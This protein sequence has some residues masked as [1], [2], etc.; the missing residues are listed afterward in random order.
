MHAWNAAEGGI[1]NL[2]ADTHLSE[3]TREGYSFVGWGAD[4]D[5]ETAQYS[6]LT[7]VPAGTKVYAVWAETLPEEPQEDPEIMEG[8]AQ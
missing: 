4:R 7:E 3:P 6:A 2:K 5:S 8:V 1:E